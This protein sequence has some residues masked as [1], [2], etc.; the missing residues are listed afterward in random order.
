MSRG[1]KKKKVDD[2]HLRDAARIVHYRRLFDRDAFAVPSAFE[3]TV[4]EIDVAA[5]QIID[6]MLT[7][8]AVDP[9]GYDFYT[10][11]KRREFET[12]YFVS[13]LTGL[14]IGLS[15]VQRM[16]AVLRLHL[17]NSDFPGAES[18]LA[19]IRRKKHGP[20][21]F[22]APSHIYDMESFLRDMIGAGVSRDW[23]LKAFSVM[24]GL[25]SLR[26]GALEL[27]NPLLALGGVAEFGPITMSSRQVELSAKMAPNQREQHYF[28][29]HDLL[30]SFM[31]GPRPWR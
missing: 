5:A 4:E 18:R 11:P 22:Q 14:R 30:L 21:S 19:R 17:A 7:G 20:P 16:V 1:G 8:R 15:E 24:D 31:N 27:L 23:V 13:V 3:Q 2:G 29:E 12:D 6:A 25:D 10:V 9:R 26:N 28:R